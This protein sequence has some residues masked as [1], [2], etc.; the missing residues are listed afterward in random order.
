MKFKTPSFDV[1][2]I[3]F[4]GE[5]D[6]IKDMPEFIGVYFSNYIIPGVNFTAEHDITLYNKDNFLSDYTIGG[7]VYLIIN[8]LTCSFLLEKYEGVDL[9]KVEIVSNVIQFQNLNQYDRIQLYI[10]ANKNKTK[11]FKYYLQ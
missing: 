11:F 9:K 10:Y 1:P 5:Y 6:G 2:I 8:D 4:T 3:T 7:D